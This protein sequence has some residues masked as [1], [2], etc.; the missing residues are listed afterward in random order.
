M[1][2]IENKKENRVA[3]TMSNW[4]YMK[5]IDPPKNKQRFYMLQIQPDLWGGVSLVREYGRLGQPGRVLS[6]W[7]NAEADALN[8]LGQLQVQKLKRGYE[9][10]VNAS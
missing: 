8:Y 1:M 4:V 9:N 2:R 10:V 5:C 6:R 3:Q 7:F